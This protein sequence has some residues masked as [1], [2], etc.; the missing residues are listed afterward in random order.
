MLCK[1]GVCILRLCFCVLCDGSVVVSLLM[2]LMIILIVGVIV[3][4]IEMGQ[5]YYFQCVMQNVVDVVVLVVVM[6]YGNIDK[7]IEFV[8]VEVKV[9]VQEFGFIDGMYSMIVLSELIDC[10]IGLFEDLVCYKVI[11]F[12]VVLI[13]FFVLVGFWGD[14]N[15]G[16]GQKIVVI[17]VVMLVGVGE[18]WDICIWLL[19]ENSDFFIINGV[20]K[21]FL[22]KCGVFFNGDVICNG[23]L[24]VVYVFVFGDVDLRCFVLDLDVLKL[25]VLFDFY[26]EFVD[27]IVSDFC[28]GSYLGKLIKSVVDLSMLICGMVKLNMNIILIDMDQVIIIFN[29]VLDFVGKILNMGID[30]KIGIVVSVIVVFV[31]DN[32][33]VSY[34]LI[35][36]VVN[37]MNLEIMVLKFGL[38]FGVVFYQ[39][40]FQ[41][42]IIILIFEYKGQNVI[43]NIIGLVYLLSY[44]VVFSGVVNKLGDDVYCFVLVV[45]II[46]VDGNGKIFLNND[47]C[48]KVGFGLLGIF[49]G[50]DICERL[51][52]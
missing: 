12:K 43:W 4:V 25:M 41:L 39:E 50:V 48:V 16:F 14:V 30:F 27:N 38:W 17:V 36:I 47:K 35:I 29:G 28:K 18:K 52:L 7:D 15:V 23:G 5:W 42:I 10:L 40:W 3:M 6:I 21:V 9:I 45:Y 20:F 33:M 2:V 49:I 34:G 1:F 46:L 11:L 24:D 37:K 31:G 22:E 44:D 51:V 19:S 8:Q 26:R 13:M 32:N